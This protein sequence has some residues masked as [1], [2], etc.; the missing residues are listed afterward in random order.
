MNDRVG[1]SGYAPLTRPTLL[2]Y[3]S[4]ACRITVEHEHRAAAIFSRWLPTADSRC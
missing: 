3:P 2:H 1:L 4:V